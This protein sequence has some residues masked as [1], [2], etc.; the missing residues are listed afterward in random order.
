MKFDGSLVLFIMCSDI[1]RARL[2]TL[3]FSVS[4]YELFIRFIWT[5]WL[6]NLDSALQKSI[7][8]YIVYFG[9]MYKTPNDV[10]INIFG[11]HKTYKIEII[12][13][14]L[15]QYLINVAYSKWCLFVRFFPLK[16]AQLSVVARRY[17]LMRFA[18]VKPNMQTTRSF[19]WVKNRSSQQQQTTYKNYF[20][21]TCSFSFVFVLSVIMRRVHLTRKSGK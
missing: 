11:N 21:I 14:I 3:S 16:S 4:F 13:L 8:I 12:L 19:S 7:C 18:I 5:Y 1:V 20:F 2:R 6:V 10:Y 15:S 9:D 17:P